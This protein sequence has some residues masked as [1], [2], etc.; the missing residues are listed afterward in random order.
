MQN[1][2]Y[3]ENTSLQRQKTVEHSF[4]FSLISA[5]VFVIQFY[6]TYKLC[7]VALRWT[8]MREGDRLH[9]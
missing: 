3:K 4:N 7:P 2:C 1:L 9:P 5:N 8:F 6:D